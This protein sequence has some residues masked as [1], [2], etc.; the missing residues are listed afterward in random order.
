VRFLRAKAHRARPRFLG[1]E[2]G[3][4]VVRVTTDEWWM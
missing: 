3:A 2:E 1:A 4:R